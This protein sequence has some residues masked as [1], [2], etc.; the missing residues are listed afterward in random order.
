MPG[1]QQLA[2]HFCL[3]RMIKLDTHE[4]SRIFRQ[5]KKHRTTTISLADTAASQKIVKRSSC[6]NTMLDGN[7]TQVKTIAESQLISYNAKNRPVKFENEEASRWWH[8]FTTIKAGAPRKKSSSTK[9]R[10][11]TRATYLQIAEL[12][13]AQ[14]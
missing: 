4:M 13:L 1:K 7:Q 11:S 3:L 10:P 9:K 2:G 6:P 12:D 14:E 5:S 8:P